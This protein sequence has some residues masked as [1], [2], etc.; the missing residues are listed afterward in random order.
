MVIRRLTKEYQLYPSWQ[1]KWKR[2]AQT[3]EKLLA[4]LKIPA[5]PLRVYSKERAITRLMK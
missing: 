4:K 2:F 3:H 5:D 1:K